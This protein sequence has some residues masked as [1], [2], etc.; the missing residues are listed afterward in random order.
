[1]DPSN[2]KLKCLISQMSLPRQT[3]I[4]R[5]GDLSA[6]VTM[7]NDLAYLA[8]FSIALDESTDI[9]DNSQLAL[10]ACYVQKHF[11]VK[12]ELLDLAALMDT[13]KE[14]T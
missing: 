8:A 10:L 14:L 5:I 1:M 11:S 4:R 3:I 12:E 7:K 13:T 2:N 6:Y 9:Q